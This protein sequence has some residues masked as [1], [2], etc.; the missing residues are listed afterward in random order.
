VLLFRQLVLNVAVDGRA[1]R[2]LPGFDVAEVPALDH[3]RLDRLC[4]SLGKPPGRKTGGARRKA[5]H[6]HLDVEPIAAFAYCR[7]HTCSHRFAHD[8]AVARDYTLNCASTVPAKIWRSALVYKLLS[9][10]EKLVGRVGIE[11]TTK[12]LRVSCST[13]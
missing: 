13:S 11:P 10:L 8:R 4:P 12:R 5:A 3:F 1:E 6:T 9:F 2:A 7:H